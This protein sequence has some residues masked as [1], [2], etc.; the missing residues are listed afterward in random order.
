[1]HPQ[2]VIWGTIPIK[3]PPVFL[4]LF[5]WL[6]CPEMVLGVLVHGTVE[7]IDDSALLPWTIWARSKVTG[8]I[9]DVFDASMNLCMPLAFTKVL[10]FL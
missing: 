2:Y 1:M 5:I 3:V 9:L 7:K 6:M 8:N 4:I 10:K